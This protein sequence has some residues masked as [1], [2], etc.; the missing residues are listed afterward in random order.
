M[1]APAPEAATEVRARAS[2]PTVYHY[3]RRDD[4]AFSKITG[5]SITA[6]CGIRGPVSEAASG[7]NQGGEA[8]ICPDCINLFLIL[9]G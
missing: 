4:I 9:Q 7:A 6:L 3:H 2:R 8:T 1:T 5:A